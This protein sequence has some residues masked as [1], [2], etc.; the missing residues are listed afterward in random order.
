M[1]GYLRS[2]RAPNIFYWI[3]VFTDARHFLF[4]NKKKKKNFVSELKEKTPDRRAL[5]V[6]ASMQ[7]N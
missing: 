5:Q 4:R 3:G 6:I 1:V 2:E 7:I